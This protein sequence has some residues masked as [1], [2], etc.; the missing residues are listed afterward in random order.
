MK[1][2]GMRE[3]TAFGVSRQLALAC[4][5]V[6]GESEGGEFDYSTMTWVKPREP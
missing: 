4:L 5:V 6:D 1:K 3:E 2:F